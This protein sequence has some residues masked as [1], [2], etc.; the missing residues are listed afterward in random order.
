M[1]KDCTFTRI[2]QKY[3]QIRMLKAEEPCLGKT[4]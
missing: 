4:A 1:M 2:H 3:P